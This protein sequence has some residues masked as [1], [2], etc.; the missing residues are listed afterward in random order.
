MRKWKEL[1][2]GLLIIALVFVGFIADYRTKIGLAC[3]IVLF[4]ILIAVGERN[5]EISNDL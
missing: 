3:D 1:I 5:N 2:C 4:V